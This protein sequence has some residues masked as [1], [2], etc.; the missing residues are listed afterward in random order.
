MLLVRVTPATPRRASRGPPTRE[1]DRAPLALLSVDSVGVRFGGV[2]ALDS[3]SFDIQ[4]GQICALI[5]PNGAGKTTF[6]NVMSRL[7]EAN[8]GQVTFE[9]IDVLSVPVHKI[10]GLGV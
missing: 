1:R 2:V 8:D 5:G 10:V 4:A 9:G 3:L 6:F 7:Y